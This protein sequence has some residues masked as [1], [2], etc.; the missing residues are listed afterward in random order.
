MRVP[1]GV[2]A[3][4]GG[5]T[6]AVD[7]RGTAVRVGFHVPPG[8]V[9]P[10]AKAHAVD[11]VLALPAVRRHRRLEITLPMGDHEL[12]SAVR[13]QCRARRIRPAGASVL[14]DAEIGH[15]APAATAG[16]PDR[17]HD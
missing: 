17:R 7:E 9:E 13:N 4:P 6:A 1:T 15:D 8:H 16:S 14:V 10:E 5:I 3:L 11:A 12:L 2:P